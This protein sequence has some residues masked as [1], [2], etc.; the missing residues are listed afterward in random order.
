MADEKKISSWNI[1]PIR[2]F[3]NLSAIQEKETGEIV[4][5]VRD[6]FIDTF[7]AIPELAGVVRAARDIFESLSSQHP[8]W[9]EN[10]KLGKLEQALRRLPPAYSGKVNRSA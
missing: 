4:A 1:V 9:G 3:H 6:E 2:E 8:T 5:T 10:S 7:V